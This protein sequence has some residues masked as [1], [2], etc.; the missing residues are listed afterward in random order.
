MSNKYASQEEREA[1]EFAS[2]GITPAKV[3]PHGSDKDIRE[4]LTPEMP[5][6]WI[7]EGNQLIGESEKGRF[8]QNIPTNKL[9][10]GTDSKGLPIFKDIVV[11]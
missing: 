10:V 4:Y 9:L 2:L 7:Q 8:V 1:A 6:R 3:T 11:K 5:T